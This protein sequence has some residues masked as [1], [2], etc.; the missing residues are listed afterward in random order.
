MRFLFVI[1]LIAL[2]GVIGCDYFQVKDTEG[3]DLLLKNRELSKLCRAEVDKKF[4]GENKEAL[5]KLYTE[6]LIA[7]NGWIDKIKLAVTTT[8]VLDASIQGYE[9]FGA[10]STSQAFLDAADKTLNPRIKSIDPLIIIALGEAAI[11]GITEIVKYFSEQNAKEFEKAKADTN[12]ELEKNK[13][14][15]WK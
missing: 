6:A 2:L 11:K 1:M 13:W 5:K 14:E 8:G 9:E 3:I 10:Q 4:P 7:N 12:K 15:K